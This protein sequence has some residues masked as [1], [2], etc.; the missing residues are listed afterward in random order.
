MSDFDQLEW[1][2]S[3]A[4]VLDVAARAEIAARVALAQQR[5]QQVRYADLPSASDCHLAD[6]LPEI[7][8]ARP[9][10]SPGIASPLLEEARQLSLHADFKHL[11]DLRR[12]ERS[13]GEYARW[14]APFDRLLALP[15]HEVNQARAETLRDYIA[16]A[17]EAEPTF[18]HAGGDLLAPR[19]GLDHPDAAVRGAFD[20]AE[21]Q[22]SRLLKTSARAIGSSLLVMPF[23]FLVPSGRFREAYYWDSCFGIDGLL[24]TGRLEVCRMQADNLLESIRRFGFVPNGNRDYYLS[25]SQVPLSA[26]LVRKVVAASEREWRD[27]GDVERLQRLQ[28]WVRTRALP[29]LEREFVDFWSDPATRFDAASGLH[30]HWDALDTRRPERYSLDAEDELGLRHRDLRASAE[31]GL[32]FTA[33][34]CGDSGRIET[35]RIATVLLNAVLCRF[36]GDLAWLADYA[37]DTQTQQRFDELGQRRRDALESHLWDEASGTYRNFHLDTQARSAHLSFATFAPLFAQACTPARAGRVVQAALPQLERRGGIA[38]SNLWESPH[39]WDGGNG[40][41]PVQMIA[42]EGLLHYGHQLDAQRIAG[43]WLAKLGAMHARFGQLFERVDLDGTDL[44]G[45]GCDQYPVQEGFLWT[46]AS[47]AW[48]AVSVLGHALLPLD[49]RTAA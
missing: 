37:G 49:V 31:S 13:A 12:R 25:R 28:R 38:A 2:W 36:A 3:D 16:W 4:R 6:A 15:D 45:E 43:K 11:S 21:S 1:R 27:A 26:T 5:L 32:D 30:H 46:N 34:D 19:F 7:V 10:A 18:D 44:P 47:L 23:P 24:A 14:Q 22:W 33:V 41:A 20:Y 29:L 9:S 48:T 8:P 42:I 40:W 39:Q 17:F 35:S